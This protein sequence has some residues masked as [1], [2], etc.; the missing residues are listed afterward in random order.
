MN[1]ATPLFIE[2]GTYYG[3]SR[4]SV[5]F[6]WQGSRNCIVRLN[7]LFRGRARTPKPR[8]QCTYINGT[9]RREI[10]LYLSFV[11]LHLKFAYA[12]RELHL[13]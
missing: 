6:P 3:F 8:A 1:F 5:Y 9:R 2:R 10:F 4:C 7:T 13:R 11:A 12:I